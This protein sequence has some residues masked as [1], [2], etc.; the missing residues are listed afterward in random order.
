M[1]EVD[2]LLDSTALLAFLFDET[3]A[4]VVGSVILR[5]CV[6]ALTYAETLDRL[7]RAGMPVGEAARE[8]DSL[9]LAFEPL[10]A[11]LVGEAA[12]L[13]PSTRFFGVTL[14]G[15]VTLA[16]ALRHK[17]PAYTTDKTWALPKIGAEVKVI[18]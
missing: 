3:G 4:D 12:Q 9:G 16:L 15:R 7:V 11:R 17:V 8:L 2:A 6:S 13:V 14:S 10:D 5:A 1:R 18:R